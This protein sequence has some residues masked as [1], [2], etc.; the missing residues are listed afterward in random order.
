MKS[1]DPRM[2][3]KKTLEPNEKRRQLT[4][5]VK[6]KGI[7][8][9]RQFQGV[10]AAFRLIGQRPL[11]KG[12]QIKKPQ[13]NNEEKQDPKNGHRKERVLGSRT[14]RTLADPDQAHH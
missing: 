13:E 5:I 14:F 9:I 7:A 6:H 2:R 4:E 12:S 8:V 3:K 1:D 10:I 11:G